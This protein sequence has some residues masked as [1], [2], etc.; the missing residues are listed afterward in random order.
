MNGCPRQALLFLGGATLS[1]GLFS[2]FQP[3]PGNPIWP[4]K[5]NFHYI[6]TLDPA[7]FPLNSVVEKEALFGLA[8]WRNAKGT[9]FSPG[10]NR[11]KVGWGN[12]RDGISTWIRLD[13][14]MINL[15]GMSMVLRQDPDGLRHLLQQPEGLQVDLPALPR[16]L[17]RREPRGFP[18]RRPPRDGARPRT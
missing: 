6:A 8:D 9:S 14:S 15:L 7:T 18:E 12:H 11:K 17:P 16:D 2:G 13:R 5:G 1:F 10:Y 4:K 3:Y